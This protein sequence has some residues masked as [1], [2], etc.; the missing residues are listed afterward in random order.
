MPYILTRDKNRKF[1]A[2]VRL[3]E[4]PVILGRSAKATIQIDDRSISKIH[5][6]L[7][8]VPGTQ[9]FRLE[10][11][12]S[13]NGI[14]HN[15]IRRKCMDLKPG[16]EV[17]LGNIFLSI[18]GEGPE[19]FPVPDPVPRPSP[20]NYQGEPVVAEEPAASLW[21]RSEKRLLV[22]FCGAAVILGALAW[23][24]PDRAQRSSSPAP[25]PIS[26][27]QEQVSA[28]PGS[29]V[30]DPAGTPQ[31]TKA[32]EAGASSASAAT[33]FGDWQEL[34]ETLDHTC[35]AGGCHL[36]T[37]ELSLAPSLA[38]EPGRWERNL[39][40][41]LRSR[42]GLR[43]TAAGW[44]FGAIPEYPAHAQPLTLV[45]SEGAQ[46]GLRRLH[47]SRGRILEAS[48]PLVSWKQLAAIPVQ[49]VREVQRGFRFLV[50]RDPTFRELADHADRSPEQTLDVLSET[51]DFWREQARRHLRGKPGFA[52]DGSFAIPPSLLPDAVPRDPEQWTRTLQRALAR[53]ARQA[54]ADEA[55]QLTT[56]DPMSAAFRE[57]YRQART[58]DVEP[59]ADA[60][61]R[62]VWAIVLGRA[63]DLAEEGH[64]AELLRSDLSALEQKR[65]LIVA[66]LHGPGFAISLPMEGAET[67]WVQTMVRLLLGREL[68]LEVARMIA[69]RLFDGTA[70]PRLL[71]EECLL[72]ADTPEVVPAGSG[73]SEPRIRIDAW[74]SFS[75]RPLLQDPG[76]IPRVWRLLERS[77]LQTFPPDPVPVQEL[78]DRALQGAPEQ[79]WIVSHLT[80]L[81]R[82]AEHATLPARQL[83]IAD[84]MLLP[85]LRRIVDRTGEPWVRAVP[86]GLR[87]WL[88]EELQ[89][90][91]QDPWSHESPEL[92]RWR[93][94][95]F[96]LL[97]GGTEDRIYR[98]AA[99]T[100][101]LATAELQL[102]PT[103]TLISVPIPLPPTAEHKHWK[104][105]MVTLDLLHLRFPKAHF[106]VWFWGA[107]PEGGG[108]ETVRLRWG[109]EVDRGWVHHETEPARSFHPT[110]RKAKLVVAAQP[111][112]E[113]QK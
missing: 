99:R 70:D 83:R 52:A 89:L 8:P 28:T 23:W 102:A 113:S 91:S 97:A 93:S 49:R 105:F 61:F 101:L 76:R 82:A 35:A 85:C 75:V 38:V 39:R 110:L 44:E 60:E 22:I 21:N 26:G 109:P 4:E 40:L 33:S 86:A 79:R 14:V 36:A 64:I 74:C 66:L 58:E 46:R 13:R 103:S 31:A 9:K 57:R 90:R 63:P 42:G 53:G 92:Q 88:R 96:L 29:E 54:G 30:V 1:R 34:A 47:S 81:Q 67:E 56:I 37:A 87:Q 78:Y 12:G 51:P 98:P 104:D 2:R 25:T 72:A 15:G 71:L 43:E 65:A 45:L 11:L 20:S 5:A 95:G 106:D 27:V 55:G 6:S 68:Q 112:E 10:D 16:D 73:D 94:G 48:R 69:A 24:I 50:G 32:S 3:P 111:E 77:I 80:P 19:T 107:A 100:L 62:S 18:C 59:R 108:T 17:R 41:L 84:G 7:E